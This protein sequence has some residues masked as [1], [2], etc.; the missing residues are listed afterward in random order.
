MTELALYGYAGFID[1]DRVESGFIAGD[2]LHDVEFTIVPR[3]QRNDPANPCPNSILRWCV[4]FVLCCVC[5]ARPGDWNNPLP[6][7]LRNP[8]DVRAA[9]HGGGSCGS[10]AGIS[11]AVCPH[12]ELYR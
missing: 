12:R 6:G 9:L 4:R 1:F 5:L 2:F 11:Y 3:L 7:Q 10:E 8:Q